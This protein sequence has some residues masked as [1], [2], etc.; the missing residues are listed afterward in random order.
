MGTLRV[1]YSVKM[2]KL[3]WVPNAW[4]EK[5]D[6][7]N[8]KEEP[9]PNYGW[10]A[11]THLCSYVVE[12]IADI[13]WAVLSFFSEAD[14]FMERNC[15]NI[16]YKRKWNWLEHCQIHQ[17]EFDSLTKKHRF[18]PEAN[19]WSCLHLIMRNINSEKCGVFH[20]P[21]KS[22]RKSRLWIGIGKT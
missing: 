7:A 1:G 9:I 21:D 17:C 19:T 11:N 13:M 10:H 6:V 22:F 16:K 14:K 18:F 20:D 12:S 3:F 15:P 5:D 8:V 2:V 4:S